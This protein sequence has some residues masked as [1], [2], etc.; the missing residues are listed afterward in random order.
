MWKCGALWFDMVHVGMI[1]TTGVLV[2]VVAFLHKCERWRP[3]AAGG[4]TQ[5]F[6]GGDLA[7]S[8]CPIPLFYSAIVPCPILWKSV[9]SSMLGVVHILRNHG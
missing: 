3:G 5:R 8:W 6:P 2:A 7:L 4:A 9:A 1:S